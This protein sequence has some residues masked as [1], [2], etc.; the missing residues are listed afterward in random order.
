MCYQDLSGK[1]E[2]AKEELDKLD[3]I[4]ERLAPNILCLFKHIL[5][6]KYLLVS[7]ERVLQLNCDCFLLSKCCNTFTDSELILK[8]I[9]WDYFNVYLNSHS[10][11]IK[12]L[13]SGQ[14]YLIDSVTKVFD[15]SASLVVQL[16]SLCNLF[17]RSSNLSYHSKLAAM[18]KLL[19]HISDID[20]SFLS[21][22]EQQLFSSIL[23]PNLSP[24]SRLSFLKLF[25]FLIFSTLHFPNLSDYLLSLDSFSSLISDPVVEFL[26]VIIFDFNFD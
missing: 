9:L 17:N 21:P 23:A 19:T 12:H 14:L 11:N 25:C 2:W 16:L 3:F 18:P 26:A 5:K 10:S 6:R 13:K 8:Y 20:I 15:C 4:T 24:L 22:E 1:H 7:V